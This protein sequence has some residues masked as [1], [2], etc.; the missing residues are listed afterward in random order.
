[1]QNKI[2]RQVNIADSGITFL[3]ATMLNLIAQAVMGMVLLSVA[4]D[5]QSAFDTAQVVSMLVI[6]TFVSFVILTNYKSGISAGNFLAKWQTVVLAIVLGVV[7]IFGFAVFSG[8]FDTLLRALGYDSSSYITLNPLTTILFLLATAVFAPVVEEVVFRGFILGGLKSKFN[9]FLAV[10]LSAIAFSL[11][12][13]S[14]AQTAYQFCLGVALGFL[15]VN[16]NSVLPCII[17]HSASNL[18]AFVVS[19]F[20]LNL[21]AVAVSSPW[22]IVI[23]S[24]LGIVEIVGLVFLFKTVKKIEGEKV[25]VAYKDETA[26]TKNTMATATI[27]FTF[28]TLVCVLMW[29][30]SFFS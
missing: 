17:A 27:S 4:G 22:A 25:V 14:P 7:S 30:I 9:S 23:F 21:S 29:A 18:T 28:A 5:N 8:G 24:L 10:V 26:Q 12:H 20:G 3:F 6:P 13:F 19:A 11:M 1:M 2:L 15:A 16:S